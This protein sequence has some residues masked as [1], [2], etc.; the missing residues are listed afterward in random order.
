MAKACLRVRGWDDPVFWV[1]AADTATWS[2]PVGQLVYAFHSSDLWVPGLYHSVMCECESVCACVPSRFLSSVYGWGKHCCFMH[3]SRFPIALLLRASESGLARSGSAPL[4]HTVFSILL[5][6]H[7][8]IFHPRYLSGDGLSHW[9]WQ[10]LKKKKKNWH[11]TGIHVQRKPLERGRS[12]LSPC[13]PRW[14]NCLSLSQ[15]LAHIHW[16]HC[17][18]LPKV[19]SL[20]GAW[21]FHKV[22]SPLPAKQGLSS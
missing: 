2:H 20:S 16:L 10:S 4:T 12:L 1:S 6:S 19:V 17:E 21:G 11:N 15:L 3:R 7:T 14:D 18:V 13:V 8:P 5:P 9:K 22:K